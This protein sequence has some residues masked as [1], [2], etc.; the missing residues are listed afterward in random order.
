MM[1]GP[2]QEKVDLSFS[3]PADCARDIEKDRAEVGLVPVAEIARQ[4]LE[5]VPGVGITCQGAV[6]SILVFSRVPWNKVRTLAADSSS[7]TSVELARVILREQHGVEPQITRERPVLTEMLRSADAALVI[8]DPALRLNPAAQG[9]EW[10][11]LGAEWFR[12]TRLPFVFAAWAGKPGIAISE[13]VGLTVESYL[14]G[15]SRIDAIVEH[16]F[17]G[18]GVTRETAHCYLTRNIQ[19]V[20]GG[21]EQRGLEAFFEMAKLG[22]PAL[23]GEKA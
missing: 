1:H 20:I 2:Q 15:Q 21:A 6:R 12:L 19:F 11:D 9:F 18:R 3:I 8:G 23:A 16:E 7:R 22:V 4:G 13:L 5:I 14:F 10:M 17:A